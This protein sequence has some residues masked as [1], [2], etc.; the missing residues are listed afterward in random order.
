MSLLLVRHC[1]TTGQSADDPLTELGHAQAAAL[2][3]FLAGFP[4]ARLISSPYTRARQS[5]APFAARSGLPVAV[6]PRLA[7]R[8]I[9]PARLPLPNW[10]ELVERAFVDPDH[11]EP[12]GESGRDVLDRVWA[13]VT[14][15]ADGDGLAAL[16][17]HGHAFGL[18]LHAI[19]PRFGFAGH[20]AMTNPDVYR[21]ERAPWRFERLWR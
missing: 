7:E 11:R 1:Q 14:E 20:A 18:L 13:A 9:A 12:G 16:V 2:T 8:T 21:L 4:V 10:R 15:A 17:G 5:I 6:D 3:E 19:D